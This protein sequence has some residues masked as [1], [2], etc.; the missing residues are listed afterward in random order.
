MD[1]WSVSMTAIRTNNDVEGWHNRFNT[2]VAN[3]CPVQFLS[4]DQVH[5]IVCRGHIHSS[6]QYWLMDSSRGFRGK[7]SKPVQGKVFG[8]WKQ[9]CQAKLSASHHSN[10]MW[11]DIQTSSP[12]RVVP[13]WKD[14]RLL[15]WAMMCYIHIYCG[16]E[17]KGE[18]DIETLR[19]VYITLYLYCLHF[20][21][22][23]FL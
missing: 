14:L 11:F 7:K 8:F 20:Y 5:V 2:R 21:M 17:S 12:F 16:G 19:Y 10:E 23:C 22:E 1:H 9:Y 15:R 18:F 13:Y 6:M 4:P 3:R